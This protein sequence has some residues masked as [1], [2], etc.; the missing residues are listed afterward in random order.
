MAGIKFPN[1][2][3][4]TGYEGDLAKVESRRKLA[5][6]LMQKG[7]TDNPN[8]QS[9]LQVLAQMGNAYAGR[10]LE[11][12]AD[13]MEGEVRDRISSDYQGKVSAFNADAQTLTPK[14]LVAKYRGDP[15]LADMVKPYEGIMEAG[16][17]DEQGITTFNGVAM[18][19]GDTLGKREFNPNDMVIRDEQGNITI[20]PVRLAASMYSNPNMVPD[21]PPP[22]S[23]SMPDPSAQPNGGPETGAVAPPLPVPMDGSAPQPGAPTAGSNFSGGI[24]PG[25]LDLELLTPQEREILSQ[26]LA[27]RQGGAQGGGDPTIPSGSPLAAGQ[28]QPPAGITK[29]GKPFWI[30]NGIPYDNPEGR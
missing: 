20:N 8:M 5:D 14:E 4:P 2:Q 10:R 22:M 16:M 13:N 6:L 1:L 21:T 30:V 24:N 23:L 27:R 3:I 11:R 12:K 9:W 28:V 7:L 17:K 26:E 18:R 29:S 25:G 19:K 15:L